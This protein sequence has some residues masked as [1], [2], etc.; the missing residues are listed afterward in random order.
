V[1]GAADFGEAGD[2][3]LDADDAW[4]R[5]R[6]YYLY[7]IKRHADAETAAVNLMVLMAE[8]QA[9]PGPLEDDRWH[10]IRNRW[11]DI[12]TH[13]QNNVLESIGS[14]AD[15]FA[16]AFAHE[17]LTTAQRQSLQ[18]LAY[19]YALRDLAALES[20]ICDLRH[21]DRDDPS[22]GPEHRRR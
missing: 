14:L 19:G 16:G 20:Q 4:R 17:H 13:L 5:L 6:S 18:S 12:A 2:Q 7:T 8:P 3:D 21:G 15:L 11:R 1:L 9:E 22:P 10:I